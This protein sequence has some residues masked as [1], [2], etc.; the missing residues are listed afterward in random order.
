MENNKFKIQ[1]DQ[2]M[3]PYHY[4][5]QMKG[6]TPKI[7]MTI[8]WGFEYLTYM[9]IVSDIIKN[10]PHD[11]I[12]DIGCGDGYLLNNL[13]TNSDKYGID[14]SERAIKLANALSKDA[15]FE[16]KDLFLIDNQYDVVSLIEV[17]EHI[18]LDFIEKFI[19]TSLKLVK[20]NGYFVISVPTDVLP[21]NRKHYRHYNKKLLSKHIESYGNLELVDERIVYNRT[22]LSRLIIKFLNNKLWT[23]NSTFILNSFW[24]WHSNNNFIANESNGCHLIRVYK[25]IDE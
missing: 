23:I 5:A 10:L 3:F 4:L 19:T 9:T 18:P 21:L 11:N 14:L 20:L 6:N 13:V 25:K 12:L 22:F 1:D 24:K 16:V 8:D 2:Y 15:N 7:N 17:L